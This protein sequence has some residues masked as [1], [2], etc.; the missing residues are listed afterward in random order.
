MIHEFGTGIRTLLRGFAVFRS[1]PGLM[2]L[3]LVPAVIA[4]LVLVALLVPLVISLPSI[5]AWLTPFADGWATPW[6]GLLR[7]AVGVVIAAAAVALASAVFTALTL[8]IGDPFY[9]RI[10]QAVEADLGDPAPVDGGRFWT[11]AVEGLRLIVFGVL[12]AIVVLLVGLIP[13]VGG[14]AGPV[15]GVVLSGRLLARE[16]MGRSFDARDLTSGQRSALFA[17]SRARVLGFG[18]A[19]QLCVLVPGG[20]IFVM[21]AAVAASTILARDLLARAAAVPAQSVPPAPP[22]PPLPYPGGS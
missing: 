8:T 10:W 13:V 14:V 7:A 21:P 1:R 2:L 6:Q 12:I 22:P 20:A 16:L 4:V 15:T 11:T 19:T 17:R 9:Q 5:S 18:V 3:G